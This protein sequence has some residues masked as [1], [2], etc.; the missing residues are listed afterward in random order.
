MYPQALAGY[1]ATRKGQVIAADGGFATGD[2][3]AIGSHVI[4][5]VN[6]YIKLHD[7]EGNLLGVVPINTLT[8]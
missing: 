5:A 8:S 4:G 7:M 1:V 6:G 3:T 2:Y